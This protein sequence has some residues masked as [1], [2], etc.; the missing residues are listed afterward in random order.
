[1]SRAE[2]KRLIEDQTSPQGRAFDIGVQA[3]IVVWLIAYS[4]ETLPDL[5]PATRR[6]VEWIEVGVTLL[7]TAEYLLRL[8]VADNRLAFVRSGW[9]IIDLLSILPFYLSLD[10]DLRSVRIL[11]LLRLF[12]VLKLGRFNQALRRLQVAW[13]LARDEFVMFL[14]VAMLLLFIAAAGI[15]HFENEAQPDKF[16]SIFASL[17]WA[18]ATLTTV[19]YG[20]VYPVTVGGRIFTFLVLMIGLGIVAVPAG[21]VTAALTQAREA[22]GEQR[23]GGSGR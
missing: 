8:Y 14:F 16:S 11:R 2:L 9:G 17:W 19:G 7:F 20:D 13:K 6:F 10:G 1:M 23:A 15:Y 22:E 12:R 3:L 4:I 18:V 5:T 21:L